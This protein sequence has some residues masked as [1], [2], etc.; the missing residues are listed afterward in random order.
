MRDRI[1]LAPGDIRSLTWH[2]YGK[3][4]AEYY[5]SVTNGKV[6]VQIYPMSLDVKELPDYQGKLK[7]TGAPF[8]PN[9]PRDPF[10]LDEKEINFLAGKAEMEA[11]VYDQ[12]VKFPA[13]GWWSVPGENGGYSGQLPGPMATA[14]PPQPMPAYV[15]NSGQQGQPG[16]E[17]GMTIEETTDAVK[18]TTEAA[19]SI[20]SLINT[21]GSLF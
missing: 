13:Y 2:V 15:K 5:G 9:K 1:E 4:F 3:S 7:A 8:L 19:K 17:D 18:S 12:N 11:G 6:A 20:G 14:K 10:W 16:E 21:I